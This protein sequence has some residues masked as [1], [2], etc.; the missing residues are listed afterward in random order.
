MI[1]AHLSSQNNG[2]AKPLLLLASFILLAI[3]VCLAY[4]F[5]WRPSDD[6]IKAAQTNVSAMRQAAEI[7]PEAMED[8]SRPEVTT[9]DM[10]KTLESITATYTKA[11]ERI[12]KSPAIK[13]GIAAG[14]AFNAYKSEWAAYGQWLSS[15]SQSMNIYSSIL[16]P[17]NTM[18]PKIAT[19]TSKAE[20]NDIASECSDAIS[21]ASSSPNNEFNKQF[22]DNYKEKAAA[23]LTATG[24]YFDALD[25]K[26]KSSIDAAQKAVADA[27]TELTKAITVTIDY[28]QSAPAVE[29]FTKLAEALNNQKNSFIR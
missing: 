7:M 5:L 27:N 12:E 24:S 17:C 14:T 6:D 26:K 9:I 2:F 20:F 25:T 10:I 18:A 13:R 4:F 1:T 3:V 23:V 11:F 28:K 15:L 22:F 8:L 29:G 19:T 16:T 21:N